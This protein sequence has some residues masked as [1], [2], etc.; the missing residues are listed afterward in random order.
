MAASSPNTPST[1]S[2]SWKAIPTGCPNAASAACCAASAP[3]SAAPIASGCWM[4]Y[5]A[6]L[7]EATR[8]A[9]SACISSG[10]V[11]YA[12]SSAMSRNCPIVTSRRMIAYSVR[13]AAARSTDAVARPSSRRSS[14]HATSRSPSRTAPDR[15]KAAG[16]PAQPWARCD[17][18]SARCAAGRPRRVS[19]LSMTSSCTSAA[20]WKTS[21]EAATAMSS[22]GGAAVVRA[23]SSTALHP[24][25]QNRPRRRLPPSRAV[26]PASTSRRAS[27]PRSAVARLCAERKMFRR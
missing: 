6:D 1:S 22:G 8:S 7:R 3:A 18:S 4:L 9:R 24:A 2:R 17:D 13:A 16:S 25:M 19:E 14:L 23:A 20:A 15:P 11:T 5:L 27:G 12:D 21:R 10:S 26:A